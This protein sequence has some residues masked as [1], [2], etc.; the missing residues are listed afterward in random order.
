MHSITHNLSEIM[1]GLNIKYSE[2]IPDTYMRRDMQMRDAGSIGLNCSL[3]FGIISFANPQLPTW[4]DSRNRIGSF[5]RWYIDAD[6]W[7]ILRRPFW[8]CKASD[9]EGKMG[10]RCR[11]N[12]QSEPFWASDLIWPG[13]KY[14]SPDSTFSSI[15]SISSTYSPSPSSLST[16]SAFLLLFFYWFIRPVSLFHLTISLFHLTIFF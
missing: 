5:N 1:F 16:F 6:S 8:L 12:P 4:I 7:I 14:F 13:W 11:V 15:H 9:S 2:Y 3:P 10:F